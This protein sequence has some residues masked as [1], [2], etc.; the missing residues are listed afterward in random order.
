MKKQ[1]HRYRLIGISAESV[2]L[3]F[4]AFIGKVHGLKEKYLLL[5]F[6]SQT[7]NEKVDLFADWSPV[8]IQLQLESK[9]V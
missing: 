3:I 9:S 5:T 8:N 4:T 2:A 7:K 1:F 6:S